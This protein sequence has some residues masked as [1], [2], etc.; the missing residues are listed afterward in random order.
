MYMY[1]S[2]IYFSMLLIFTELTCTR[3]TVKKLYIVYPISHFL[4]M[5]LSNNVNKANFVLLHTNSHSKQNQMTDHKVISVFCFRKS[6]E[7]R[8]FL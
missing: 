3:E 1:F 5:F 2:L 4:S 7:N 8:Y 6:D